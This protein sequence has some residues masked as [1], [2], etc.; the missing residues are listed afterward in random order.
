MPAS[1]GCPWVYMRLKHVQEMSLSK[2]LDFAYCPTDSNVADFATKLLTD[3]KHKSFE[4]Q[5]TG[6]PPIYVPGTQILTRHLASLQKRSR[7]EY[8][9]NQKAVHDR[10][11]AKQV[12]AVEEAPTQVTLANTLAH[13]TA[14]LTPVL[15]NTASFRVVGTGSTTIVWA[16][17]TRWSQHSHSMRN[18]GE[19]WFTGNRQPG[20]SLGIPKYKDQ[21]RSNNAPPLKKA[22]MAE[23]TAS[24]PSLAS[25]NNRQTTKADW[26]HRNPRLGS[27][28]EATRTIARHFELDLKLK[29]PW[30]SCADYRSDTAPVA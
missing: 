17:S 19:L 22:A 26:A 3:R 25:V 14:V 11:V 6:Q 13:D 10:E 15:I 30:I 9:D 24:P 21:L 1:R 12:P 7:Q 28:K 8:L 18:E 29:S 4:N 16:S 5:L 2:I 27:S 20:S 23:T